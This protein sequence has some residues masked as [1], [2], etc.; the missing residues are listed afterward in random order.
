M[1]FFNQNLYFYKL[2]KIIKSFL[3]M[4]LETYNLCLSSHRLDC[5]IKIIIFGTYKS[6]KKYLRD[7]PRDIIFAC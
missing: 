1:V 2:Q 6:Y 7:V 3:E 5:L 4:F